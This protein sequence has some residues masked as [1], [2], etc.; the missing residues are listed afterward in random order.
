M[1]EGSWGSM[2]VDGSDP[3]SIFFIGH[4]WLFTPW[5]RIIIFYSNTA[6]EDMT[7]AM[8][9][10]WREKRTWRISS[11]IMMGVTAAQAEGILNFCPFPQL[12]I[13]TDNVNSKCNP[14]IIQMTLSSYF[15]CRYLS[16]SVVFA[17]GIRCWSKCHWNLQSSLPFLAPQASITTT[18]VCP[19][20]Y[21]QLNQVFWSHTSC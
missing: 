8:V 10:D 7:A 16:P 14:T 3:S 4:L 17:T 20:P 15:C 1:G 19:T 2:G 9:C 6:L 11:M 5:Y 21:T 18:L 12:Y 13:S